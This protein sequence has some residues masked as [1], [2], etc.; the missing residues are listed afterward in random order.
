MMSQA[1]TDTYRHDEMAGTFASL[2]K[3]AMQLQEDLPNL[4]N[5]IKPK[6]KDIVDAVKATSR[7][8]GPLRVV[9][10][11]FA[12][13]TVLVFAST[14]GSF[15]GSYIIGP[16]LSILFGK[17]LSVLFAYFLIPVAA[18]AVVKNKE[19]HYESDNQIRTMLL[20]T[21]LTQGAL[22]GY[23]I[24]HLYLSGQPL[25]FV[26]PAVVSVA[27]TVAV[28]QFHGDR[29]RIIGASLGAALLVNMILGIMIVENSVS[30][31]FLTLGY[32]GIA[33]IVMQLVF[34]DAQSRSQSRGYVYQNALNSMY[35]LF[36]GATFYCFGT[37][38][39]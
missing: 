20:A 7:V 36:K 28:R 27:Y 38:I 17:F 13:S 19:R 34:Y 30:Y 10:E 22:A 11:V 14:I 4:V 15:A 3:Q 1:L 21:A 33:G 39:E 31:Q 24:D 18:H 6:S 16:F 8:T 32:C 35:L 29:F 26:T 37:Y 5:D 25:A 23:T 2:R 9:V 12:W